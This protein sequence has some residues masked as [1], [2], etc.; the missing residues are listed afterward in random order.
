MIAESR[1]KCCNKVG[2][3]GKSY[4]SSLFVRELIYEKTSAWSHPTEDKALH[5]T[6]CSRIYGGLIEIYEYLSR[7]NPAA[8]GIIAYA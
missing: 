6:T 1:D 4:V 2:N 3:F 7:D 5:C 8:L